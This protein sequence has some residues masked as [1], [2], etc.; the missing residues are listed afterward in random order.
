[1]GLPRARRG[2]RGESLVEILMTV[3]IVSIAVIA[4][5]GALAT[6]VR[7]SDVHRKQ[8]AV[9]AALRAFAEDLQ[10]RV[11]AT[12]TAY[13][14]A[15]CATPADYNG[16]Y[17]PPAGY[18]ATVTRVVFWSDGQF[19]ESCPDNGIQLLTLRVA[20]D[21]ERAVQTLDVVLR[22]PCRLV[23]PGVAGCA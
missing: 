20:S 10:A 15:T 3:T 23:A 9:S 14:D 2:D 5:T 12:P 18:T 6:S 1:M 16:L 21:D 11:S 17:S 22:K 13:V 8:A 7:M 4:I 19:V